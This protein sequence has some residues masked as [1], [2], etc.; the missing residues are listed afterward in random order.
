MRKSAKI[1]LG[2]FISL[3]I[4]FACVTYIY[5]LPEVSHEE[6]LRDVKKYAEAFEAGEWDGHLIWRMDY[7]RGHDHYA[8]AYSTHSGVWTLEVGDHNVTIGATLDDTSTDELIKAYREGRGW[9][10]RQVWNANYTVEY[11]VFNGVLSKYDYLTGE[12]DPW[13]ATVGPSVGDD[14]KYFDVQTL[15][16]LFRSGWDGSGIYCP[17]SRQLAHMTSASGL[18]ISS[19]H[20][21]QVT[22]VFP[23]YSFDPVPYGRAEYDE[24]GTSLTFVASEKG[25]GAYLPNGAVVDEKPCAEFD[26]QNAFVLMTSERPDAVAYVYAGDGRIYRFMRKTMSFELFCDGFD[27]R[28]EHKNSLFIMES[29]LIIDLNGDEVGAVE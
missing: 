13:F 9:I 29:G 8:K 3:F 4:G 16:E 17:T 23:A 7:H 1:I 20:G 5:A 22:Q 28:P 18:I 25:A 24:E 27:H 6:Q 26:A 21:H 12:S 15:G 11:S 14:V 2:L 19:A 10:D